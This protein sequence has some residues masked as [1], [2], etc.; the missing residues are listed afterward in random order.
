MEII[1]QLVN[2]YSVVL[3]AVCGIACAYFLLTGAASLRELRR[4][5]FRLERSSVVSHAVSALLKAILCLGI[6]VGIFIFTTLAPVRTV[7]SSLLSDATS[8]PISI[9]VPTSMPTAVITSG[10][11]LAGI[12]FTPTVTFLDN[13]GNPTTTLTVTQNA[14]GTSAQVTDTLSTSLQPDCSNSNAQITS[15]AAGETVVGTYAVRG[16]ASVEA[17]GWYKLEILMPGTVQWALVGR[18][19]SIVTNNVLMSNFPA[20]NFAPGEYPFRLVLIGVDGGIRAICRIP[21]TI[22]S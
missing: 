2:R 13:S 20:G 1:P 15:P 12:N 10:Q 5:V 16:T 6:G 11:A 21:I 9:V 3:Y 14:A 22:G 8:T 19:D 7:S 18:G 17:G 4:S